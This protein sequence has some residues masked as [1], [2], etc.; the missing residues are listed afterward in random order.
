[1]PT[2]NRREVLR[3]G[4]TLAAGMAGQS[5]LSPTSADTSPIQQ[6]PSQWDHEYT[7]GHTILFMEEYHQGTMQILRQQSGE[8]DQIG[9]LA[10]RAAIVIRNGGTVWTSMNMGHMTHAEQKEE[11]R[12]SPR[13]LK[14]HGSFDGL[15]KGDMV[16]TNH[17]NRKVLAARERGVY[18]VCV[19]TNYHDNEF[20]PSGF[21]SQSFHRL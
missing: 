9:E 11:R 13:I 5:V 10:S 2:T 17:A 15:E 1:M 8:L 12:G 7:F 4:V 21:T 6:Q 18:V 19:T 3:A 20:R 14:D 16:F